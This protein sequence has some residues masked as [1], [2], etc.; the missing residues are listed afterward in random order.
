MIARNTFLVLQ[1]ARHRI[2]I[3]Y[4]VLQPVYGNEDVNNPIAGNG[5][6]NG[7]GTSL[8]CLIS[9]IIIKCC[10]RKGHGTT[11][12]TP[13]SKIIVS[14]LGFDFVDDADLVTAANNAYQSD[15]EMI[16]KMQAL[17]I[18]WCGCIRAT[19]GL[20]AATKSRWFLVSFFWNG[21]DWEYETKDSLLGDITL[22]DK[23][24][25]LYTV[26]REEPT[27]PFEYLGLRIDLA[28][29]SSKALDDVTF[30]CNKFSTQM[31]NA[32][33]NKPPV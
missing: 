7:L 9:T 21:N 8:W 17:M 23:D 5:Q 30:E 20:I 14:L 27:A 16:Q 19:G 25:N 4:G 32:K 12:K 11:I 1:Q 26:N 28:N 22:P 2:K 31:D 29:T 3:G 13:I 24:G 6:V 33:C 18:N 15:G 10:K